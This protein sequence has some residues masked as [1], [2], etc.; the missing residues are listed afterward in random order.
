MGPVA[1]AGAMRAA[2]GR[3]VPCHGTHGARACGRASCSAVWPLCRPD[4]LAVCTCGQ[5]PTVELIGH[6]RRR[7]GRA[8][9]VAGSVGTAL[10]SLVGARPHAATVACEVSSFQLQ[11]SRSFAPEVGVL[12]NV[13]PAHLDRHEPM[14]AYLQAKLKLFA[15]QRE[16]DFAIAPPD[17]LALLPDVRQVGFGRGRRSAL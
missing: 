13:A 4:A 11:D 9:A 7:A 6:V 14:D 2:V 15:R 10:S 1:D 5:T 8:V 12:L 17:L 16:H 3:L